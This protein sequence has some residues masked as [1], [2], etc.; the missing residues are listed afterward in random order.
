MYVDTTKKAEVCMELHSQSY[1]VSLATWDHPNKNTRLRVSFHH[2]PREKI[3]QTI[4]KATKYT[5]L[6]VKPKTFPAAYPSE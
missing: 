6:H 1:G 2:H 3:R 5:D 4:Q